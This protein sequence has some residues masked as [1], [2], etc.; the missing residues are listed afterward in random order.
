MV[1]LVQN[2]RLWRMISCSALIAGSSR[3]WNAA[4][5]APETSC[6]HPWRVRDR[7]WICIRIDTWCALSTYLGN[8]GTLRM[9]RHGKEG[10]TCYGR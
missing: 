9:P 4:E 8:P 7:W 5:L 10:T 3:T 6:T 2:A 1:C